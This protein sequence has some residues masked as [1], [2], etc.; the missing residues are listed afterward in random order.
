[1]TAKEI[2]NKGL[3]DGVPY[4]IIADEL[5]DKLKMPKHMAIELVDI[6]HYL[7]P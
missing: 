3:G 5:V 7:L 2:I 4:S 6:Y 1:M